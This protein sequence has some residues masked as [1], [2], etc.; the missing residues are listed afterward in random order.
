M[1]QQR[2]KVSGLVDGPA[3]LDARKGIAF[4]EAYDAI[5]ALQC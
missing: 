2:S 1:R 4:V 3:V 5:R